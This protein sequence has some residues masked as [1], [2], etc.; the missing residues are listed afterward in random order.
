M[1]IESRDIPLCDI[2]ETRLLLRLVEKE[3]LE[4]I[5]LRDS[6]AA[7]GPLN[8][9]CVRPSP[10][11]P[12]KWE[13]VDGMYRYTAYQELELSPVPCLVRYGMTD[14][15]VVAAQI[16]ANAIRPT[17]KATRLCKAVEEDTGRQPWH[18]AR[19]TTRDDP[20]ESALDRRATWP[21]A[22]ATRQVQKAVDRGEIPLMSAYV[23]SR[24]LRS[25]QHRFLDFART[26]PVHV[27]KA[28][29]AAFIKQQREAARQGKLDV[30]FNNEFTP[31]AHLRN[32]REVLTEKET[33]RS[34][35]PV[36]R[37]QECTDGG[38]RLECLPGVDHAPRRQESRR[39]ARKAAGAN[40]EA[41]YR[42]DRTI[43]TPCHHRP[44]LQLA[45]PVSFSFSSVS[46]L[47]YHSCPTALWS[48]SILTQLP[49]TQFG[50]DDQ[51]IELAKSTDF[52]GRLQLYTKGKAIN[53][54]QVRPGHY[55]I[56]EWRRGHR[57][58]RQ[59]RHPPAGSPP[60][61]HRHDRHGR[62]DRQLRSRVGRVQADRGAVAG[63]GIALH[64][65][66]QLPRLSSG[67]PAASWSSSAAARARGARPR[68]STRSCR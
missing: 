26:A 29:V 16:Q 15:M 66:P 54:G 21:P 25:Q 3:S 41:L 28:T 46:T 9:I 18:V 52:I 58:G 35:A 59:H 62:R 30:L 5:E 2:H 20:Q 45:F 53:K 51:F 13:V 23:L 32:L 40:E 10:R 4:Y 67:A 55:G 33:T 44:R 27:F 47:R 6:L 14:E 19:A 17:T 38:R 49:S 42:G 7:N 61:G 12:G 8:S 60:E 48:P 68:R 39:A 36:A 34:G 22:S 31:V 56:P 57:P 1:K 64:V 43:V 63:K 24:V 50:T 11:F 65:R 37:R